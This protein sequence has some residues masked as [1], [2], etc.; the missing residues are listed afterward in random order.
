MKFD[1]YNIVLLAVFAGLVSPLGASRSRRADIATLRVRPHVRVSPRFWD[2]RANASKSVASL[3]RSSYSSVSVDD[4]EIFGEVC[5]LVMGLS[6]VESR[7]YASKKN[8]YT[9]QEYHRAGYADRE[10]LRPP[11]LVWLNCLLVCAETIRHNF[12]QALIQQNAWDSTFCLEPRLAESLLYQKHVKKITDLHRYIA[13]LETVS[14][15][16]VPAY[17]DQ[18]FAS[19]I[20]GT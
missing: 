5:E 12:C 20:L 7:E 11:M 8:F 15:A 3:H 6:G 13:G 9:Q 18:I 4:E 17:I 14:S 2:A 10:S 1:V 19:G 16:D